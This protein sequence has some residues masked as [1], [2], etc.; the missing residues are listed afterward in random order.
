MAWHSLTHTKT[1]N[2][3]HSRL[4]YVSQ[5]SDK[6]M[7]IVYIWK[8]IIYVYIFTFD[9][10]V[11]HPLENKWN[12]NPIRYITEVHRNIFTR[13][14]SGHNF[15]CLAIVRYYCSGLVLLLL[16][17]SH[18]YFHFSNEIAAY[19][20]EFR[21]YSTYVMFRGLKCNAHT[22]TQTYTNWSNEKHRLSGKY[23]ESEREKDR[24]RMRVSAARES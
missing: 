5:L 20:N 16:L 13:C 8:C 14:H 2:P 4:T 9:S 10:D 22:H 18:L 7:C 24:K 6:N 12:E 3:A 15:P 21:Q 11:S 1:F 17:F 23:V 19:E